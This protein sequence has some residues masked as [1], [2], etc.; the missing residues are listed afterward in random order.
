MLTDFVS[1]DKFW[2]SNVN[3]KRN[4]SN[5]SLSHSFRTFLNLNSVSKESIFCDDK[6]F[7]I[8]FFGGKTCFF[9]E[10]QQVNFWLVCW[11]TVLFINA[12]TVYFFIWFF[13]KIAM[14]I[15]IFQLPLTTN[16]TNPDCKR[17]LWTPKKAPELSS[18]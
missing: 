12:I 17:K 6:K 15:L 8:K 9:E 13:K 4:W 3:T 1:N 10:D 18:W 14:N 16:L 5:H 2:I 11:N 7:I